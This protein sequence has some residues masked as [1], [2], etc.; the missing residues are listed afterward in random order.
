MVGNG[1]AAER[2]VQAGYG[3]A[4]AKRTPVAGAEKISKDL[5]ATRVKLQS[6]NCKGKECSRE[7]R[8]QE[9]FLL[10]SRPQ[11]RTSVRHVQAREPRKGLSSGKMVGRQSWLIEPVQRIGSG[12]G[13][14]LRRQRAVEPFHLTKD[15]GAEWRVNTE[16]TP[17]N[18]FRRFSFS[19]KTLPVVGPPA[20]NLVSGPKVGAR[21][22]FQSRSEG[23]FFIPF[24]LG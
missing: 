18:C 4:A 14:F 20:P 10:T 3:S 8:C 21:A 16:E 19:P 13:S 7:I 23:P 11:L 12:N 9:L 5:V 24:G 6:G 1:A 17:R 22:N 2:A 15:K